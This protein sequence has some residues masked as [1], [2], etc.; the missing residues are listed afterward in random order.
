MALAVAAL[1]PVNMTTRLTPLLL[2]EAIAARAPCLNVSGNE[3]DT[4]KLAVYRH[5]HR[6][7]PTLRQVGRSSP[8]PQAAAPDCPPARSCRRRSPDAACL[9]LLK[10]LCSGT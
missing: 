5:M 4:D 3:D 1:S 6:V 9:Q 10:S 7:R 2:S 8:Q